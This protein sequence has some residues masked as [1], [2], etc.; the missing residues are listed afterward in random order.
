MKVSTMGRYAM[1]VM[2]ELAKH[3]SGLT[4]AKELSE[5]QDISIKYLEQIMM[6]LVR[7]SLVVSVRGSQG[8][9]R[10]A[11]HPHEITSLMVLQAV[12]GT[13]H[14]APCLDE[15]SYHCPKREQCETQ[16]LWETLKESIDSVLDSISLQTLIDRHNKASIGMWL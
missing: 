7:S 10:L 4:T 11:Y 15:H 9:Y 3:T 16:Y 6:P 1:R 14:P 5:A 8:G 2:V 12:K 13:V